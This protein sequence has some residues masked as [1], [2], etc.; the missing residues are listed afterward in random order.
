MAPGSLTR[1]LRRTG[2]TVR[3]WVMQGVNLDL[4]LFLF[5]FLYILS[6]TLRCLVRVQFDL[7]RII[8]QWGLEKTRFRQLG[9]LSLIKKVIRPRVDPRPC[10][11]RSFLEASP[12]YQNGYVETDFDR[13][14]GTLLFYY[15]LPFPDGTVHFFCTGADGDWSSMGPLSSW[16]R[17]ISTFNL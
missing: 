16:K 5:L 15:L 10:S 14:S 12:R 7:C 3:G 11:W 8:K 17:A 13:R 2:D 4:G 6:L 9:N 1:T